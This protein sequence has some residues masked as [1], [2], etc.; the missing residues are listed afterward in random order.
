V[1]R[2]REDLER[3]EANGDHRAEWLRSCQGFRLEVAGRWIGVVEEVL[4]GDD[5]L[6]A[7]L[8][9]QGGLFGNRTYIV[10]AE[11]VVEIAPRSMRVLVG[12]AS[13]ANGTD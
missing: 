9:V 7:A 5:D 12:G 8:L 2:R 10:P 6:P 3:V 1:I 13:V 4:F 11:D